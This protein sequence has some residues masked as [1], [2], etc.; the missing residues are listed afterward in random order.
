MLFRKL[1][2]V[3]GKPLSLRFGML[4]IPMTK[5]SFNG[6]WK[7]TCLVARTK[8]KEWTCFSMWYP[9]LIGIP[10]SGSVPPMINMYP[11]LPSLHQSSNLL[12]RTHKIL[13]ILAMTEIKRT[14]EGGLLL[15]K[16]M[17]VQ[18]VSKR[19]MIR[20]KGSTEKTWEDKRNS[21]EN[22]N[23]SSSCRLSRG[24]VRPN[25]LTSRII[26]GELDFNYLK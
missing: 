13:Q 9:P 24:F 3:N 14:W 2:M 16:L 5:R 12:V 21:N 22:I 6:G 26:D 17:R 25:K 15:S 19:S 1:M 23:V 7:T 10:V 11:K 18:G 4:P 8:I 20:G